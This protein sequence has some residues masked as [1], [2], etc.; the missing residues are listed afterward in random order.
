MLLR[1]FGGTLNSQNLFLNSLPGQI[2]C[3][4]AHLLSLPSSTSLF[5]SSSNL[6]VSILSSRAGP[7]TLENLGFMMAGAWFSKNQGLGS[8][9]ALDDVW[10]LSWAHVG[11]SWGLVGSS[12]GA[13]AG[14]RWH[15]EFSKLLW[16]L[17]SWPNLLF[18]FVSSFLSLIHI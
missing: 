6:L 8:K 12:V 10:G 14:S 2:D 17:P 4:F 5:S 13:F 11:C 9:D 1:A 15:L 7:P 16:G 18:F 3:F